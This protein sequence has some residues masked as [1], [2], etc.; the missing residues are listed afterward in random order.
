MQE[1]YSH[2]INLEFEEAAV[3]R[4]RVRALAHIQSRQG[5]NVRG[6]NDVD[7]IAA[8]QQAG[9]TCIQVFFFRGGSNYGNRA[10]YPIHYKGTSVWEGDLRTA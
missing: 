6:I 4:D 9:Q 7:V 3:L 1:S 2:I 10:H 5:I 8:D